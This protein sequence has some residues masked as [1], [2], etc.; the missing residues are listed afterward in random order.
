MKYKFLTIVFTIIYSQVNAALV[1]AA[2]SEGRFDKARIISTMNALWQADAAEPD[3]V[4]SRPIWHVLGPIAAI[5]KLQQLRIDRGLLQEQVPWEQLFS[6]WF[7]PESI[8]L[9]REVNGDILSAECFVS[10]F[11]QGTIPMPVP[12]ARIAEPA[13][14][15]ILGWERLVMFVHDML[16]SQG[17]AKSIMK[18]QPGLAG[19]F[20]V[21]RSNCPENKKPVLSWALAMYIHELANHHN[22][23]ANAQSD[24]DV[25]KAMCDHLREKFSEEMNHQ[26]DVNPTDLPRFA[27]E[28]AFADAMYKAALQSCVNTDELTFAAFIQNLKDLVKCPATEKFEVTEKT[29]TERGDVVDVIVALNGQK[30]LCSTLSRLATQQLMYGDVIRD[31]VGIG[32]LPKDSTISSVSREEL[33]K[34]WDVI[35]DDLKTDFEAFFS[36]NKLSGWA[37]QLTQ[38][39]QNGRDDDHPLIPV[40]G[41]QRNFRSDQH[42]C[43]QEIAQPTFG[44]PYPAQMFMRMVEV[45]RPSADQLQA[46][47]TFVVQKLQLAPSVDAVLDIAAI[48]AS[49]YG[50]A[51]MPMVIGFSLL[52]EKTFNN[53]GAYTKELFN[54][55][56]EFGLQ[57]SDRDPLLQW[58]DDFSGE[59][60]DNLEATKKSNNL[61]TTEASDNL[62]TVYFQRAASELFQ[63]QIHS[64]DGGKFSVEL[65]KLLGEIAE[66]EMRQSHSNATDRAAFLRIVNR[67]NAVVACGN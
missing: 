34:A 27:Q 44:A 48:T 63:S 12:N 16:H 61:G 38:V 40:E 55:C 52:R 21:L 67:K 11:M 64:Y 46:M 2:S 42:D 4:G 32:K 20:G 8:A 41:C 30:Y 33:I 9:F 62:E 19:M 53:R 18:Y 49:T 60:N 29:V 10:H 54:R 65:A 36:P 25:F 1:D 51:R 3:A 14:G 56:R 22:I 15:G 47:H 66:V 35:I 58:M 31:L 37:V 59:E 45:R 23:F 13:H 39:Q 5:K 6:S 57:I 28:L 26:D 50:W 7:S 43:P 17:M 24:F